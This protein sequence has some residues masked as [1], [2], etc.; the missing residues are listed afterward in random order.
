MASVRLFGRRSLDR[1]LCAYVAIILSCLLFLHGCDTQKKSHQPGAAMDCG[2]GVSLCGVLVL[3]S[4]FGHNQYRHGEPHVHGLWPETG[5]YGDSKCALPSK[6]HEPPRHIHS[7]YQHSHESHTQLLNFQQH[8]WKKHGTCA[9][10]T[11]ASDYFSQVCSLSTEPLHIMAAARSSGG[12]L[13][14]MTRA[15][16]HAGYPV[17]RVQPNTGEILLSACAVGGQWQLSETAGFSQRC[18]QDS[19]SPP[20]VQRKRLPAVAG[21]QMCVAGQHGPTCTQDSDCAAVPGCLRCAH[22][23]FCTQV[24]LSTFRGRAQRK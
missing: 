16:T 19:S 17:W 24:P 6:S 11:S 13:D 8:E 1:P 21:S 23:G 5:R 2:H 10:V 3:Q 15:L 18:G 4:G 12:G 22:S 14:S 7:C 20:P 9:G